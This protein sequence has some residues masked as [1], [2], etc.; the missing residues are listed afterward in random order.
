MREKLGPYYTAF[1]QFISR[2]CDEKVLDHLLVFLSMKEIDL[3]TAGS[4]YLK[5]YIQDKHEPM[6]NGLTSSE[7]HARSWRMPRTARSSD[8]RQRWND[9]TGRVSGVAWAADQLRME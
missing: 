1:E 8:L 3:E 5:L 6:L 2:G 7:M 9:W 4:C